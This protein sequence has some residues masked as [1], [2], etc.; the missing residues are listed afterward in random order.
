M[1]KIGLVFPGQGAQKPG[2]GKS[3]YEEYAP[4]KERL[5]AANDILGFDL[6]K[7]CFDG[8]AETLKKTDITQPALYAVSLAG[9][10]VLHDE[11]NQRGHT[12]H[13]C[14]GHSLGEYSAYAAAGNVSYEDG[15]RMVQKR[16]SLMAQADP[17]NLGTMA[18]ILKM[19]DED[20]EALCKDL[21]SEGIIVPANF[22]C[23]GQVAISGERTVIEKAVALAKER[24]GR[25]MMLPV[26]GAFHSPLMEPASKDLADFLEGI[27]F[28]EGSYPVVSNVYAEPVSTDKTK[29]SLV[30]QL[31]SPVRWTGC[32]QKMV[33]MDVDVFIEV[34]SGTI[35]QGLIKRIVPDK[36]VLGVEDKA[37]LEQTLENI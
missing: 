36:L 9:F 19:K 8:D 37:S 32:V 11:L 20:V 33:E 4:A 18:S 25:G 12:I 7:I 3:F 26:G 27:S 10:A 35:L 24:K 1:A 21:A 31:V 29:Q 2:M 28:K 6:K 22:N 23:P 15:L 13:A 30:E 14:A 34:G 5:D 16:G 17:N